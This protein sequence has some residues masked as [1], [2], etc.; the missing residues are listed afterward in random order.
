MQ[1]NLNIQ[2]VYYIILKENSFILFIK[3]KGVTF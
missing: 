2:I 1:K 3:G